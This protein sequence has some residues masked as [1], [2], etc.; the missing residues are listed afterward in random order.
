M[1]RSGWI[2]LALL[3]LPG[4]GR[5]GDPPASQ[6]GQ[7]AAAPPGPG[8]KPTWVEC[9]EASRAPMEATLLARYH[10]ELS[11]DPSWGLRCV[12]IQ[13]ADQPA[14]FVEL[15][16]AEGD[17]RRQ[18]HGV[19]ATDGKT[20]LVPLRAAHLD[21]VQLRGGKLSFETLDLDGDHAD[22]ILLHADDRRQVAATWVDVIS[23]HGRTLSEISGPRIAFEDP[24]LDERCPGV[25]TIE[26]AGAGRHL[27][28]TT[29][30]STGRSEH[31]LGDGRHEFALDADRLVEAAAPATSTIRTARAPGPR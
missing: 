31:C 24:E 22:E 18:L 4:C 25:L 7:V 21:W 28:V 19:V 27:V 30:G 10:L 3:A 6:A 14:F 9:T 2:A 20:E 15:V 12:T 5:S 26:P 1:T 29:T 11:D 16:G 13:L 8:A 23:I 17:Q